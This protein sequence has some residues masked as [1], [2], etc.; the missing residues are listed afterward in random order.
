MKYDSFEMAPPRSRFW[1]YIP[2]LLLLVAV[3]AVFATGL[4]RTLSFGAFVH[5]QAQL[6]GMVAD[7]LLMMLG[8]YVLVYVAA[9]TLSLPASAFL[10][11]VGGYLFGWLLG[12]AT[13]SVAATLGATS[14]FLI[15][16]TSLGRPLLRRA[17]TRIQSL[18]AGF[19]KQAFSYLLFL[20]LLPVMP[21]WLTNLAAAF[22]GMRLKGYVLATFLGMLPVAFAFAFAGSGLDGVVIG[23]EKA[24]QACH[25]AGRTDCTVSFDIKSLLTPEVM[26]ALSALGLLALLPIAYRFWQSRGG[27]KAMSR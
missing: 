18:A 20:R 21:F 27:R 12:G 8:L 11:T 19:Q 14:I 7:H 3:G 2:L 22:F 1:K 15:A 4:H 9:V 25:A 10:S 13:A 23:H 6:R 17:G 26:I 16:R 5:Y 24:L